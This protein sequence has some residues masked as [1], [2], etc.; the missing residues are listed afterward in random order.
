[1][2][3]WWVYGGCKTGVIGGLCGVW[4]AVAWCVRRNRV[5]GGVLWVYG[6]CM[7]SV[8]MV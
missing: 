3:L 6:G 8:L 5:E 1:V 4:C 7:A 2:G